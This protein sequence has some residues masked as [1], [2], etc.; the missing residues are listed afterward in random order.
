MRYFLGIRCCYS[1][2]GF[3][4]YH[5]SDEAK[6]FGFLGRCIFLPDVGLLN[7]LQSSQ[8]RER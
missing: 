4:A 8:R 1:R 6:R 7:K 2:S 3:G 5:F